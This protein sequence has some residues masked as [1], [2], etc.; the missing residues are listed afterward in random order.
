MMACRIWWITASSGFLTSSR[1]RNRFRIVKISIKFIFW[2]EMS[3]SI[4]TARNAILNWA[5]WCG[6]ERK[7]SS[8]YCF[9][10][11]GGWSLALSLETSSNAWFDVREDFVLFT[12][13]WSYSTFQRR[14]IW[15]DIV[16]MELQSAISDLKL[17]KNIWHVHKI[18]FCYKRSNLQPIITG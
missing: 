18:Q 10:L 3:V 2:A 9:L 7:V 1:S 13:T 15:S 4:A 11:H 16:L 6:E 17:Y 12:L 14:K 8:C 5:T